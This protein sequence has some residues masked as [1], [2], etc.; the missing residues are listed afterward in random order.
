MYIP[1]PAFERAFGAPPSLQ[2]FARAAG[3]ADLDD[4][5]GRAYASMRARRQLS[6][7]EADTFDVITPDAARLFVLQ[8]AQRIGA[9]A[10]PISLMAL[11]AS[12][13][14]VAN[15]SLVSVTQRTRDIGIRRAVG[16]P[17]AQIILEVLAEAVMTAIAGGVLGTVAAMALLTAAAGVAGIPLPTA[18]STLALAFAAAMLTGLTAGYIPARKAARLDVVM[19]LRTE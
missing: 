7:G 11:L 9:A 10:L 2:V 13:V 17:R 12:V 3:N 8:L 16:A 19:A 4:A 1:L 18:P 14:V 15:T 6:P 5:E